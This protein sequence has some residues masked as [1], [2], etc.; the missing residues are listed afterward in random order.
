VEA[1]RTAPLPAP[2]PVLLARVAA[3][4]A[5]SFTAPSAVEAFLALRTP[6]G[7]PV[8]PPPYVVCI[9][10]TTAEAARRAGLAGVH[11]ATEASAGGIVAALVALFGAAPGGGS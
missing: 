4:D 1:Y 11:E 3:A 5:L 7:A 10:P 6:D 9:G 8:P 2:P